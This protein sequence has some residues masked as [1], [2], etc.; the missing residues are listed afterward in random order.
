MSEFK[1]GDKIHLCIDNFIE[2][3]L[4]LIRNFINADD[5]III[6]ENHTERN[7]LANIYNTITSSDRFTIYSHESQYL[8][9]KHFLYRESQKKSFYREIQ[10]D[11]SNYIICKFSDL[12]KPIIDYYERVKI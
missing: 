5:V 6:I 8:L 9:C 11:E 4:S 3:Q 1:N 7:M 12:I 2:K 10:K